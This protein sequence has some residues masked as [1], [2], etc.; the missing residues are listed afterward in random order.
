ML[1]LYLVTVDS[2]AMAREEDDQEDGEEDDEEDD[3]VR[4]LFGGR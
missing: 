3:V 4:E 2:L 1:S